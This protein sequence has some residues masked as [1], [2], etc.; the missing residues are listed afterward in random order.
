MT[1]IHGEI[2][3]VAV[4]IR[5]DSPSFKQWHGTVL[6]DAN[7]RQLYVAPG[8]AH[9][10]CVLSE[11]ADVLYKTTDYYRPE[12]EGGILWNDPELG[13]DWPIAEPLLSSRDARSPL[14]SHVPDKLP[15]CLELEKL[16][17]R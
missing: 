15:T 13:I 9:G 16:G 14:L 17:L 3:D 5:P 6:S 12:E 10:F 1:V 2:F 7:H 11:A 4:D 8:F